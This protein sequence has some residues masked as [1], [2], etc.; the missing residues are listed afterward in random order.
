MEAH[1]NLGCLWLEQNKPDAARTEFTAYTLRRNNAPEGW[2]KLGAAQLRA[3]DYLSGGKKFQ[4]RAY[5]INTNNAEALNG[6]GLARVQR[7]KPRDAA[8][9]FAAAVQVSAGL[10][11][12]AAEPGDGRAPVF[13]R[14]R[15]GALDNY[16]DYLALTPRP[17]DWDAVNDL[18][19]RWGNRRQVASANP[20]PANQIPAT[21]PEPR[22]RARQ[23]RRQRLRRVRF[24]LPERRRSRGT[25]TR[26]RARRRHR[27]WKS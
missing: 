24:S 16:R 6:L 27:R 26:R 14:R 22:P 7:G 25:A 1:Y 21:A 12:R 10:R 13:A 15:G 11:A 19:K 18:V 8:Q 5:S 4:H 3:G 2:L 20:P 9:F 23:N 17:A